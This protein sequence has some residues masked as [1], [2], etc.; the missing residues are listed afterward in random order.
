MKGFE[1]DEVIK[2][3]SISF[4]NMYMT[5]K[6][7]GNRVDYNSGVV[8]QLMILIMIMILVVTS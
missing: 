2:P 6:S 4:K 1:Y 7:N 8:L 3:L 5:L